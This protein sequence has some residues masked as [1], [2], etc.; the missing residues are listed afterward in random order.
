MRRRK[1]KIEW[2]RDKVLTCANIRER[3]RNIS[4]GETDREI[5]RRKKIGKNKDRK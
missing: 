4:K 3:K 5:N 1:K 2:P